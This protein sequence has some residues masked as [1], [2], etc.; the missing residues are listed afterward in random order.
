M[1]KAA[2]ISDGGQRY[3][4][5]DGRGI[6]VT[7]VGGSYF[8]AASDCPCPLSGGVLN[9]VVEVDGAPCVE[10][11]AKCYTLAFD[12]RSGKNTRGYGFEIRV[13]PVRVE[14]DGLVVEVGSRPSEG[15][16]TKHPPTSLR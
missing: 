1:G 11:D 16:A 5:I 15:P 9:R 12:L 6:Y 3:L 2:E 10:C 13:Y 4:T 14:E 7:R 8:A